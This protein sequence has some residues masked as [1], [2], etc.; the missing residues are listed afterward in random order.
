MK[1]TFEV[2]DIKLAV[3]TP[4]A[5]QK[6]KAQMVYSSEMNKALTNPEGPAILRDA[7]MDVMVKQGLWNE[8][9]SKEFDNLIKI[10]NDGE[11]KLDA[12]GIKLS[13]TKKI[14]Y[15]MIGARTALQILLADRNKLDVITAEGIA[16]QK[17]FQYL[18]SVCIVREETGEPYFSNVEDLLNDDS[19]VANQG[20]EVLGKMIYGLKDD[21]RADNPEIKFLQKWNMMDDQYRLVNKEGKFIDYED[22]ILDEQGRRINENGQ[23]IDFEGNVIDENGN[24]VVESK[25]FLDDDGNP[26]G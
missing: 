20:F 11:R 16:E 17:Q 25:P 24:Y 2:N 3:I 12:G 23:L 13:D 6:D 18:A 21:P 9:K 14:C 4:N 5:K 19:G 7:L 22:H 10:I 26:I 15:E 8:E 1:E